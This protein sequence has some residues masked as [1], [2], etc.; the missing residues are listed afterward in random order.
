[1]PSSFWQMMLMGEAPRFG[2]ALNGISGGA[3]RPAMDGR[4]GGQA[5]CLGRAMDGRSLP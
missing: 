2:D 4:A 1:M 5:R 3:E